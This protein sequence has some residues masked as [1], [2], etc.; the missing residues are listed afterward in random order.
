ME[1]KV[2]IIKEKDKKIEK[3]GY[4]NGETI[5]DIYLNLY[6]ADTLRILQ[7]IEKIFCDN[8]VSF[9]LQMIDYNDLALENFN[10]KLRGEEKISRYKTLEEFLINYAGNLALK[11]ITCDSIKTS[12]ISIS[13]GDTL[14]EKEKVIQHLYKKLDEYKMVQYENTISNTKYRK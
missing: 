11:G 14:K 5:K 10:R 1:Q 6:Y 8:S 3:I 13:T 4:I 12:L 9:Q 7:D 2:L